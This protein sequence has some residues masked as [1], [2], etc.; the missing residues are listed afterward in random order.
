MS[1]ETVVCGRRNACKYEQ[2]DDDPCYHAVPH[3]RCRNCIPWD[4]EVGEH[5]YCPGCSTLGVTV[6]KQNRSE[7]LR[8]YDKGYHDGHKDGRRE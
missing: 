6:P 3:D 7:Y 1:R 5:S 4:G 2:G 8:G